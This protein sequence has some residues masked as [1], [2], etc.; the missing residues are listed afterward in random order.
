METD[1]LEDK[2]E[3][4][5]VK[6][7]EMRYGENPHQKAAYFIEA[8]GDGSKIASFFT[9]GKKHGKELSY[10]NIS[11]I[12]GT[13]R[14]LS[15]LPEF[16]C[17]VVK[18]SNPCGAACRESV[19]HSFKAAYE[20]DPVSIFGGIV[21]VK[22]EVERDTAQLLS[23]IFLEIVIAQRFS[24]EAFAILSKKKNIRLM[25]YAEWEKEIFREGKCCYEMKRVL[26]GFLVQ[27]RDQIS[28]FEE[29]Y[30]CVTEKKATKEELEDLKFA[31]TIVKNV[32]SNAVVIVK[33][34]MLLG[35]GAGQMNR[36]TSAKIALD[37]AGEK[38]KGAVLGSDAFFPMDDTVTLASQRGI[39]A[40]VQ[41][42]GS[43]RDED[44][45]KAC[46]EQNVAM[47]FTG[48]RHF[49]H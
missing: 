29:E 6:N 17:V 26:G 39:T 49:Y 23:Q 31:Q 4:C 43:V 37:W 44:S 27:E 2:I 9:E 15:D 38:A 35:V 24:E 13:M 45:I 48:V 8:S 34:K 28:P 33:D 46:D 20:G 41:P 1:R 14:I 25:E 47:Y 32:K 40:I 19:Y 18:H 42:G 21:G 12:S 30:R 22:G 11:D 3:C 7:V 16:S 10:N 36:V 5:L